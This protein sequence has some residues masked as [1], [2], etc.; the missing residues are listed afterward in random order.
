MDEDKIV[1]VVARASDHLGWSWYDRADDTHPAKP[2]FRERAFSQ[3]RAAIAAHKAAL[4]E[5]GMAIVVQQEPRQK[6]TFTEEVARLQREISQRQWRLQYLVCGDPGARVTVPV[7][8]AP[9]RR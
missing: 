4:A 3:F 6:E 9:E 5:A 8:A 2:I 1:E 7:A